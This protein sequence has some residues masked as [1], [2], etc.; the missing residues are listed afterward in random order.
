MKDNP[1][2][3]GNLVCYW[4]NLKDHPECIHG[5]ALLFGRENEGEEKKFYTCSACRDRKLCTF[6][7]EYDKEPSKYEK[8]AWEQ[9]K[10]KYAASY[11]HAKLF[12]FYNQ[13]MSKNP[14]N[15]AYCHTC[16][17]LLLTTDKPK[18]P[19]HQI[20][21]CLSDRQM[22]HPTELLKPLGNS[23][24]EAQYLFS[25][26]AVKDIVG[27]LSDLNAKNVLCIGAP[28]I[29]EHITNHLGDNMSSLLLDFDGR[30]HNFFGPLNYCWYNLFNHHFFHDD[31]EDVFKDFLTQD[32]GKDMYL[33]C[34]PPFGGRIEPMSQTIK[35]ISD[36]HKK[37]NKI[38]DVK[39]ELKIFFVFPYF[40]ESI[41]KEK[42]NPPSVSGGLRDLKM[43]DYKVAYNN[44]P[45]FTSKG[46]SG[47]QGSP[48]RLFTNVPMNLVKLPE[49]DG[50]KYCKR[51]D[52]WVAAENKHCKICRS[53]TSRDGRRYRHCKLCKRCVKPTWKHCKQCDRCSLPSHTCGQKPKIGS[54]FECNEKG[55]TGK[56]CPGKNLKKLV[57][58]LKEKKQKKKVE[59]DIMAKKKKLES[60][61]TLEALETTVENNKKSKAK[62]VK[63]EAANV[64]NE[65][66]I[67]K[68]APIVKLNKKKEKISKILKSRMNSDTVGGSPGNSTVGLKSNVGKKMKSALK[69]KKKV[70]EIIASGIEN[71]DKY[72]IIE[73]PSEF[74]II[75]EY[76]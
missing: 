56:E 53:C 72:F 7:L 71:F 3:P 50:Y 40:T 70:A 68:I 37:L 39:N 4:G 12:I 33:V 76:K 9:E 45:L 19:D 36:L 55:H 17:K 23:K 32:G 73:K 25:E 75:K 34:D 2:P 28:R 48:V 63:E 57:T 24:K 43:T 65:R 14:T 42:S 6:Y 22:T 20:T 74:L 21:E 66:I 54:C 5:P 44:H 30:F 29:H 38:T 27:F 64:I 26:K 58:N 69:K 13:L 62:K 8:H 60:L 41:M 46:N 35:L 16:E 15:R 1:S 10:K 51:C 59:K 18:H 47:Q 61:K 52:R 49:S 11:N 67:K 31:S